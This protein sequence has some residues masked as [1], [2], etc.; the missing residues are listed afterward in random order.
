MPGY[1]VIVG[2]PM[3]GDTV[4]F[5]GPFANSEFADQW[6]SVNCTNEYTAVLPLEQP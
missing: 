4:K 2:N 5:Y 3:K 6:I 1:I